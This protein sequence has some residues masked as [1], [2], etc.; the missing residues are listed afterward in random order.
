MIFPHTTRITQIFWRTIFTDLATDQPSVWI[1]CSVQNDQVHGIIYADG[2]RVA[3]APFFVM[4]V[5]AGF[6]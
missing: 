5:L 6:F 4:L 1:K 2:D 3:A